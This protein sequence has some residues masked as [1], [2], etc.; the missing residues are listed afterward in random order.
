MIAVV[1]IAATAPD[2]T[3]ESRV[4]IAAHRMYDAEVALHAA[5]QAH[6]D[7]WISAAYRR[8]HEAILEHTAALA[9]G[10]DTSRS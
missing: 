9:A 10:P 1:A 6:M 2:C 3:A 4:D 8:L 7:A 5:R